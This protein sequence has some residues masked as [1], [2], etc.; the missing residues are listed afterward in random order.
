MKSTPITLLFGALLANPFA[1]KAQ[2][3]AADEQAIRKVLR[4]TSNAQSG[5]D[6]KAF[7][8]FFAEDAE[9]VNVSATYAKGRDEIVKLHEKALYGVFKDID[10]K[11]LT[12][13]MPEPVVV[14]RFLRP[15]VVIAHIQQDP[16]DCPPCAAAS[17]AMR[18]RDGQAP[19]APVKGSRQVNSWVLSKHDGR[20]L[21][22]NVQV[23]V[24]MAP[25]TPAVVPKQ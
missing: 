3:N 25:V 21:I 7:G 17:A 16:G 20:W 10:F 11:A 1:I 8:Q 9:F 19:A 15:D 13:K 23:T 4:D 14:L 22:D 2:P 12:A 5:R 24:W 18:S 6:F